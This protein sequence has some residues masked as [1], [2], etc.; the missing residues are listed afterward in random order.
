GEQRLLDDRRSR[1]ARSEFAIRGVMDEQRLARLG[2]AARDAGTDFRAQELERQR[3][4]LD[5]ELA[6]ERDRYELLAV[7]DLAHVVQTVELAAQ[8]LQHLH[9]RDRTDVAFVPRGVRALARLL[10]VEDDLVLAE[11]FR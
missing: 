1:D 8:A 11:C 5:D 10:V 7:D 9:M 2:A 4:R 3:D 6:A